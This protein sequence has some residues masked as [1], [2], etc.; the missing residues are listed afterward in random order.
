M[1][2][3]YIRSIKVTASCLCIKVL[4]WNTS[5]DDV[6]DTAAS[7]HKQAVFSIVSDPR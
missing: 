2:A 5:D 1:F 4:A 3:L 6:N 7:N